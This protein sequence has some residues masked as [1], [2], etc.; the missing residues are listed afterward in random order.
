MILSA[1]GHRVGVVQSVSRNGARR[2]GDSSVQS[3]APYAEF[4]LFSGVLSGM[5]LVIGGLIFLTMERSE[6]GTTRVVFSLLS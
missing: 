2:D 3:E 5:T 1:A 6:I 4:D